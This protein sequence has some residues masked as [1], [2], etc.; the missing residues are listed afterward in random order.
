MT[1]DPLRLVLTDIDRRLA[2][3]RLAS[4][5]ALRRLRGSIEREGI[6]HPI[7]VSSAVEADRWVLLDGFKRVRVAEELG[8]A[9]V[10][11]QTLAFDCGL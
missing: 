1:G 11:A 6:R 5:T 4:P 10:W 2:S 8:L 3:L 9:C 7:V